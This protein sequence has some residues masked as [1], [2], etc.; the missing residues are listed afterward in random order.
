MPDVYEQLL[1][2]AQRV[3]A[4]YSAHPNAR[5]AIVVGSVAR[6][7][8]DQYSD[9]DM[10]VFY[11]MLPT[12]DEVRAGREALHATD[13]MR[14]PG[15]DEAE[16]ADSF[17][18]DG[19]E[20]QV[21]HC[22]IERIERDLNAVLREDST[23]HEQHVIVG[24]I[25]ESLALFGEPLVAEWQRQCAAY[26]DSLALKMVQEHLRFAPYWVYAQRLPS[27]DAP[28][29]VRQFLVDQARKLLAALSGINRLYPQLHFK[30][31]DAYA[32]RMRVAPPD[33]AA[34][35]KRML[36]STD[37]VAIEILRDLVWETFDLAEQHMPG[38]DLAAARQRFDQPPRALSGS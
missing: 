29:F 21:G 28:L 27:R 20:C 34:R 11:D 1:G 5:A 15:G 37:D 6:R 7:Q 9:I 18:L 13:C 4:I 3:A 8:Y 14:F 2:R 19:V 16:F 26:P 32:A 23:N 12:E 17:Q 35:I 30:R 33:L 10:T 31:I 25:G 24:G 38:I 36:S 22:T